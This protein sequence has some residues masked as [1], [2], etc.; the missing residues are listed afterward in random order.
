MVL[1]TL[2][3]REQ[4]LL[5]LRSSFDQQI[6]SLR[7]QNE[8]AQTENTHLKKTIVEKE[9]S[10]KALQ[11]ALHK[12]VHRFNDEQLMNEKTSSDLQVMA[13]KN[14]ELSACLKDT[15]RRLEAL[16]AAAEELSG[17]H[18][19]VCRYACALEEKL[20]SLESA[21]EAGAMKLQQ[22]LAQMHSRHLQEM[23]FKEREIA[24]LNAA[25][26]Q[27]MLSAE[28]TAHQRLMVMQNTLSAK[29]I[30]FDSQK[31]ALDAA[32]VELERLRLVQ[33]RIHTLS[34]T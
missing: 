20:A 4:V 29:I 24:D 23:G 26:R 18:I 11:D 13:R 12:T 31:R 27:E 22:Q 16:T 5:K 33:S 14:A 2:K 32:N 25:H 17:K 9:S 28:N 34:T 3:S 10:I 19:T 21:S 8:A 7:A 6:E 15:Q 30:E 1:E